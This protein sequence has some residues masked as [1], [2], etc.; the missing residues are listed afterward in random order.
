VPAQKPRN[1]SHYQFSH[2]VQRP[3]SF[4][5]KT[6]RDRWNDSAVPTLLYTILEMCGMPTA[7][8]CLIGRAVAAESIAASASLSHGTEPLNPRR[9]SVPVDIHSSD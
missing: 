3:Y 6:L 2:N 4:F 7:P 8:L 5:T 9:C 1:K